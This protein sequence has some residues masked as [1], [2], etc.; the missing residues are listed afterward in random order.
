MIIDKYF[1]LKFKARNLVK[2]F[3]YTFSS[4][5]IGLIISSLVVFIMPKLVGVEEY[6]YYQLF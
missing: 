1:K 2:N 6:G 5:L 4:N 3:S